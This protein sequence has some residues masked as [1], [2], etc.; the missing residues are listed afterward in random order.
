MIPKEDLMRSIV[1]AILIMI[2]VAACDTGATGFPVSPD[3]QAELPSEIV[4]V[5]LDASNVGNFNKALERRPISNLPGPTR[6]NYR[7]GI[8]D[9]LTVL[10]FNHPELTLPA[11]SERSAADNGFRVQADG[12]FF[13][14]FVGQVQA[15]GLA[16][17]EIRADLTSRLAEF[18]ADP[19]LEVRVAEFNSQLISV[20]GAVQGPRRLPLTTVP[21]TLVDAINLAGG[22]S[23]EADSGRVT[24][25]RNQRTYQIDLKGFLERGIVSN[26]PLLG[27]GDVVFVP[28]M[29][30]E[31]VFLLGEVGR[32]STVDLAGETVSLTQ[33]L[34]R[35]GGLD[36]IRADSR[37]VFVFRRGVTG[38]TV[39]Q[40]SVE[41]PTGYLLGTEFH[42]AAGDVVY[43]TRSPIQRWNDTIARLLP[44]VAAVNTTNTTLEDL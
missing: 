43:V 23:P 29:E 16:P 14:P 3:E 26:N 7:V 42:L 2:G 12:T 10:V 21:T 18:I 36:E 34:A 19:Q 44:S 28:I 40:L 9:I 15:L 22:L 11:G 33:A 13:Y 6:W 24:I 8:G 37:G 30:T 32:P 25:Q 4:V 31:E 38:M 20:T 39:Y 27:A 17:E 5:R 1:F 35:Q 41:S